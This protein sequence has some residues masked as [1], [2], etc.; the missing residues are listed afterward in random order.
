MIHIPANLIEHINVAYPP[1]NKIPFEEWFI[2]Q[3]FPELEREIIKIPIT[4]YWVNHDYGNDLQAKQKM[5][6]FFDGLDRSKKYAIVCQYDDQLL[7]DTKDLDIVTFGMSYRLPEQKPT[8][9]IP[10]I[11]QM[12][13]NYNWE[14]TLTASFVGSITHKLRERLMYHLNVGIPNY[15]ISTDQHNYGTY[16]DIMSQSVFSFCPV[17]YGKT[18]FR[19]YEAVNQNSIPVV[20]F[21]D[22]VMEPYGIDINEYGVKVHEDAI[23]LIPEILSS[24]SPYSIE[25]KRKRMKEL[26]NDLCT[27]N[28]VF[29]R[30]I[31]TLQ[32]E[33]RKDASN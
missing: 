11:G 5:Q 15:Y 30:I 24:F 25:Q 9:V 7:I 33:Q 27:Y 23:H 21:E 14:K 12:P 3:Q 6:D 18:S 28:G 8:Y 32:D 19:H 16:T 1:S 29:S 17:G 20:I 26:Y 22:E 2:Q 31:K 4:S 10:L 13:Q